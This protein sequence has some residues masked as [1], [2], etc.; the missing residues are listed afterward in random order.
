MVKYCEDFVMPRLLEKKKT[1]V[2]RLVHG[3]GKIVSKNLLG[4]SD[5]A[6]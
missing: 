1:G 3:S 6:S 2:L 4:E 5:P